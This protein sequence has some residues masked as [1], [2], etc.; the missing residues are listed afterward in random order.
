ML[1]LKFQM[2]VMLKCVVGAGL[3]GLPESK[4]GREGEKM[5]DS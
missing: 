2:P 4:R 5:G 1:I 3:F